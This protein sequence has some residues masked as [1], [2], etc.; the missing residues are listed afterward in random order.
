MVATF[1]VGYTQHI[2]ILHSVS[3]VTS[4]VQE[5]HVK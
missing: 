3:M 2:L 1:T 4:S 5:G